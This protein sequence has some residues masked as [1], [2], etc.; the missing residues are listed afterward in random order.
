MT[1]TYTPAEGNPWH[2]TTTLVR[3][4]D[5]ADWL[6]QERQRDA[7]DILISLTLHL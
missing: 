1:D 7:G 3:H 5:V 6:A 4:G 2:G